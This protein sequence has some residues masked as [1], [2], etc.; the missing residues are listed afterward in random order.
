M[1]LVPYTTEKLR[2]ETV[3]AINEHIAEPV[4]WQ[5]INPNDPSAYWRLLADAW[6]QPDDL[7]IIEHDIGIHGDVLAQFARCDQPWCGFPY[8]I[9]ETPLVC[10]GC[11]RFTADLK[12]AFPNLLA[13]VAAI[14]DD[15]V[16]AMHW[17]RLDVRLAGR[18]E[19]YGHRRHYHSPA[20]THFH[21]Y[22]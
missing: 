9:G 21:T 11:T 10:L 16:P 6:T 2:P 1:I 8:L 13:D 22:P 4:N 18:L 17:C 19:A 20:V 7:I 3:C 12:A 5:R 15:N 14:S